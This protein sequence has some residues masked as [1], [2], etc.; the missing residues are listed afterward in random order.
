MLLLSS[1][2][3]TM[4]IT[5]SN[6]LCLTYH[7]FQRTVE[8]NDFPNLRYFEVISNS[9]ITKEGID[10]LLQGSPSQS[11]EAFYAAPI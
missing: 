3:L 8:F 2:A 9:R 5:L 1:P 10:I 11:D 6:C 7:V 4:S